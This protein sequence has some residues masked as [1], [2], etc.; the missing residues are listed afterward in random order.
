MS[1]LTIGARYKNVL[2]AN[3]VVAGT[4][5]QKNVTCGILCFSTV[6]CKGFA[7]FRNGWLIKY[8]CDCASCL[9]FLLGADEAI[10]TD[11]WYMTNFIACISPA[12]SKPALSSMLFFWSLT[13]FTLLSGFGSVLFPFDLQYLI[14]HS[15]RILSHPSFFV[16]QVL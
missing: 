3:R 10:C 13:L 6:D 1:F 5:V 14:S 16:L 9:C 8:T 11:S 7:V 15:Y 4:R 12:F 2:I